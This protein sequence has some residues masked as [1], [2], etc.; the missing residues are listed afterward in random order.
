[1]SI[2]LAD[3]SLFTVF[4]LSGRE[5]VVSTVMVIRFL[6]F[7]RSVYP[8]SDCSTLEFISGFWTGCLSTA[9]SCERPLWWWF[10]LLIFGSSTTARNST[11]GGSSFTTL[12]LTVAGAGAGDRGYL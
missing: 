5:N 2:A 1:L 3:A 12:A 6:G 8:S 10:R 7:R 4:G 11:F 9:L